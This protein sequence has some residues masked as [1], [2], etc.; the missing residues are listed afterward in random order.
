M[1]NLSCLR[2]PRFAACHTYRAPAGASFGFGAAGGG[3]GGAV[4]DLLAVP[5]ADHMLIT[6]PA[7]LAAE[8]L[9][10]LP[11][12]VVDGYRCV[13]PHLVAR[14]GADVLV[15]GAAGPSVGLY[16]VATAVALGA[17]TIG[18]VDSDEDRCSIAERLGAKVEQHRGPWPRRFLRAAITVNNTDDPDGLATTL[19]STDDYGVC[20]STAIFFG[21]HPTLAFLD[22]YTKGITL[23]ISR[24][25]SRLYTSDVL[26]MLAGGRLHTQVVTT[27]VVDW[28]EA[29]AAWLTP[30]TKLVLT[31]G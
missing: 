16:A 3:H 18:Y 14:P 25:D 21:P 6:A 20:T 15:V 31:R 26:E 11:D 19:R 5:H 28:D 24:A 29:P 2:H 7:E 8:V 17:S 30:S 1:R 13:A 12:N 10:T 27:S 4:A 9:C 23:H 22:L